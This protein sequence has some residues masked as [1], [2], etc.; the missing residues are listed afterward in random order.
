M[1]PRQKEENHF[2]DGTKMVLW[3]HVQYI[4]QG[5]IQSEEK[6]TDS[7]RGGIDQYLK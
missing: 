4:G 2:R 1:I 6:K 7:C 3:Y 5:V